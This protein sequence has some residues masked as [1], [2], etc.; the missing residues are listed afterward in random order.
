MLVFSSYNE[1][2]DYADELIRAGYGFS[3]L[4][5]P[6]PDEEFDLDSFKD[7]FADWNGREL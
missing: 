5:D 7:M 1:V 2:S 3:V 6:R 4:D